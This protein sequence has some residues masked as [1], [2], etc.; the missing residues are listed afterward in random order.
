MAETFIM[1]AMLIAA[2]VMLGS[3]ALWGGLTS[4]VVFVLM[5]TATLVFC[6]LTLLIDGQDPFL[7]FVAL[8]LAFMAVTLLASALYMVLFNSRRAK[9]DG[10]NTDSNDLPGG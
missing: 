4:R 2:T 7:P 1:F 9:S 3:L 5:S 8:A 10:T 6:A